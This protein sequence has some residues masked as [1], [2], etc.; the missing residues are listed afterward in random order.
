[1]G[2]NG[3]MRLTYQTGVATLIQFILVSFFTLG[4]QTVSTVSSCS[5]DGSNCLINVITAIIFYIV[6]AVFFGT[7]WII[8][9]TAQTRRGKRWTQLLI[10]SEGFVFL[11]AGFSLKLNLR[12]RSA[13]GA[14]ASF[15]M[16]VMTTWILSLAFRLLRARGSRI[17]RPRTRP[18]PQD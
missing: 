6:I 13:S 5:K 12:S 16:L 7:I 9:Y 14:I 4:S 3:V 18:H 17:T 2:Y 10:C 15:L 8:G 11:L 1:M